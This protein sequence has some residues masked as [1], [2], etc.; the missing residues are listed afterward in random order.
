MLEYR[1]FWHAWHFGAGATLLL[2]ASLVVAVALWLPL[3]A[4]F[5]WPASANHVAQ[6]RD[7]SGGS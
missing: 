4:A 6:G 7:L 3:S 2:A 1:D 5:L